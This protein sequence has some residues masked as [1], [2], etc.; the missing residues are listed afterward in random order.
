MSSGAILVP[1]IHAG[2]TGEPE[3]LTMITLAIKK[4]LKRREQ[5]AARSAGRL[6]ASIRHAR[7]EFP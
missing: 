3:T 1:G 6:D 7:S 5:A 2:Q 4:D